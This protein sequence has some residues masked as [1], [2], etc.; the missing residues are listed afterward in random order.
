MRALVLALLLA[1]PAH[2]AEAPVL[3]SPEYLNPKVAEGFGTVAPRT[4]GNG[5]DPSGFVLH[6]HWKGWGRPMAH[7]TG[8]NA[9]FRLGGGYF[10]TLAHIQLRVRDLGTCPGHPRR[11]YKTLEVRVPQWPG[12]PL[13]SWFKWSGTKDMC[14]GSV[15]DTANGPGGCKSVGGEFR[16]GAV[17]SIAVYK[18]ACGRARSVAARVRRWKRPADCEQR[19]CET[20]IRGL[21]CRLDRY[22]RYDVAG[23]DR[24]Y[25]ALRLSCRN[26]AQS[27]SAYLVLNEAA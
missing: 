26:G 4:I 16:P 14:D 1:S 10:S 17:T 24:Q 18:V 15:Y 27:L 6:I 11:A 2:A 23:V 9:I 3:G 25:K 8:R 12:G 22:H 7:G 20:R 13:G 5:G 21:N 19:G